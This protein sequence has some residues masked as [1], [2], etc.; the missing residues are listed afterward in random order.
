MMNLKELYTA[1]FYEAASYHAR[2]V[3]LLQNPMF[4]EYNEDDFE[5]C[6][7]AAMCIEMYITGKVLENNPTDT[8]P[9]QKSKTIQHISH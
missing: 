8:L 2:H 9:L 6:T 4:H 1:H 7:H 5:L 3:R